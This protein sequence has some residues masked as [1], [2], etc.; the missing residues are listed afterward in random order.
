MY[1]IYCTKDTY[2]YLLSFIY[3]YN[4]SNIKYNIYI[5]LLLP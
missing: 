1:T 4:I 5:C 2:S 3:Y